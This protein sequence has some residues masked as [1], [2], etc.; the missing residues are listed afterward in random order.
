MRHSTMLVFA[1]VALLIA[2]GPALAAE[3]QF[4]QGGE[5]WTLR[6]NTAGGHCIVTTLP[7]GSVDIDC[8]DGINRAKG[9]TALGCVLV[10]GSGQCS[11]APLP[12]HS[13]AELEIPCRGGYV[14]AI[15]TGTRGGRCTANYDSQG[16]VRGGRCD[17]GAGNSSAADCT[18]NGGEGDCLG[19][20]GAGACH[21][22]K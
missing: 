1:A 5:T 19:S 2:T 11:T 14:Y 9:N 22:K 15:T 18:F 17:D 8:I 13:F 12:E 10:Q 7:D 21:T 20:S 3:A 16:R 4:Q 6:T